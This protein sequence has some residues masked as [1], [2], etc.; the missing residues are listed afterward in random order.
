MSQRSQT[1]PSAQSPVQ[2]AVLG[3][4][5][6]LPSKVRSHIPEGARLRQFASPKDGGQG[7]ARDLEQALHKGGI[8]RV[9]ILT[10][11][12]SHGITRR[13]RRLCRLLAIP[14]MLIR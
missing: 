8:D 9:W 4:D 6:R 14:V 2:I 10:R 1:S 5:G 12:N 3:G 13:I 11:W 7:E